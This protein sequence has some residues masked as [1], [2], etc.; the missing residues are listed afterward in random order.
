[1]LNPGNYTAYVYRRKIM[2]ELRVDLGQEMVWLNSLGVILEKNFQIWHHRRCIFEMWT[3][4]VS[5][6]LSGDKF[7]EH[8][9]KELLFLD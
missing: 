7:D 8:I 6:E 9:T 2:H 1:L 3:R 5:P 4:Q